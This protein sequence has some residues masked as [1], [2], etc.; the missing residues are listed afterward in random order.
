MLLGAVLGTTSSGK[1]SFISHLFTVA[2]AASSGA[3]QVDSGFSIIEVVSEEEFLRYSPLSPKP[4][5]NLTIRQLKE[6]IVPA[7]QNLKDDARYG[8]VFVYGVPF[9]SF[10]SHFLTFPL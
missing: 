3:G 10:F 9:F 6:P 4:L 1:S 7:A 8:C 5:P 2:C